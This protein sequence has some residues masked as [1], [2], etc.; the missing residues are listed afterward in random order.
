M[1]GSGPAGLY[2]LKISSIY[3]NI[4]VIYTNYNKKSA[5]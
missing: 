4:S 3:S 5:A 1:L 2:K